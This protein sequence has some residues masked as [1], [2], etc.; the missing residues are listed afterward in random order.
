[1]LH[2][3]STKIYQAK[4]FVLQEQSSLLWKDIANWNVCFRNRSVVT[5][6]SQSLVFQNELSL[7]VVGWNG[8]SKSL[9]V[10]N[11]A[12]T[13]ERRA[14]MLQ[15]STLTVVIG[16]SCRK[17]LPA[18]NPLGLGAQHTS[19]KR[20][21]APVEY[22]GCGAKIRNPHLSASEGGNRTSERWGC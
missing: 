13:V 3:L 11:R 10:S 7:Y 8:D 5:P 14:N 1:M 19:P 4:L 6:D 12:S 9:Q 21:S 16:S 2:T 20:P 15:K 22:V 17:L 18:H